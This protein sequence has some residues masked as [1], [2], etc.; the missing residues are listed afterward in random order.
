ML[1]NF[2]DVATS[3]LEPRGPAT[4]A[5]RAHVLKDSNSVATALVRPGGGARRRKWILVAAKRQDRFG[6]RRI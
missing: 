2:R 1:L 4:I 3:S 6:V 5:S